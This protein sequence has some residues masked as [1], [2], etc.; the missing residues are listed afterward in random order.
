MIRGEA[1][2]HSLIGKPLEDASAGRKPR[3]GTGSKTACQYGL[4]SHLIMYVH[5]ARV[6]HSVRSHTEHVK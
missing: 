3:V 5:V 1:T 2:E 6:I 4:L